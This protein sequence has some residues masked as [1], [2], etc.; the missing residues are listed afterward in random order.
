MKKRLY[1]IVADFEDIMEQIVDMKK[2]CSIYAQ[3]W[4]ETNLEPKAQSIIQSQIKL[5]EKAETDCI[6]L[7]EKLDELIRDC[8]HNRV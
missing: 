4:R 5:L 7:D 2:I 8:V 1:S 6:E 3:F